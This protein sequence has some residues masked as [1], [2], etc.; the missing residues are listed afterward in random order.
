[1]LII[2]ALPSWAQTAADPTQGPMFHQLWGLHNT[3]QA[4]GIGTPGIRG[5]DIT[6]GLAW[7]YSTGSKANVVAVLDTGIAYDHPDLKDNLWSA[8]RQFT[9]TIGGIP[10]TCPAGTHGFNVIEARKILTLFNPTSA[11]YSR[12]CNPY[13]DHLG[14]HGTKISGIIGASG[15]NG[16]GVVGV[17]WTASI[18]AVKVNDANNN[19]SARNTMYGIEFVVQVKQFFAA[20]R[21]A[22]VRVINLSSNGHGCD[23]STYHGILLVGCMDYYNEIK[24]AGDNGMLFVTS[25]GNAGNDI[26]IAASYPASFSSFFGQTN[27]LAVAS[28]DNKDSL[29]RDSNYG[30]TVVDL[31]APGVS[32]LSTNTNMAYEFDSGTSFAAPHVSGAAL[33][34]LSACDQDTASLRKLILD[35]VDVA[36]DLNSRLF[37]L[38]G[39]TKTGGRLNVETAMQNCLEQVITNAVGSDKNKRFL[40][41]VPPYLLIPDY[42]LNR[43]APGY[44][45]VFQDWNFLGNSGFRTVRVWLATQK[46][47]PSIRYMDFFDPDIQAWTD[48]KQVP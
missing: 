24:K 20:T 46:A 39:K 22:N 37:P 16:M 21:E 23:P 8:P 3:G 12:A 43:R 31:A 19:G 7:T 30:A 36:H 11:D 40:S 32:I 18:M 10:F 15:K 2:A 1:L 42:S 6:A 44:S 48:W 26:S 41:P 38:L 29:A 33:L 45:F 35:S 13:D 47:N 27:I 4:I 9:V 25:A 17:N 5:A 28:T 34:V 14:S